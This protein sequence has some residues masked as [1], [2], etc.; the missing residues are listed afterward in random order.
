M[1]IGPGDDILRQIGSLLRH[2]TVTGLSDQQLLERFANDR[3]EVA[4]AALVERH[5]AMVQRACR[6]ILRDEHEAQDAFQ[7][8][9]LLLARRAGRLWI[10]GSLAP[11]L[12]A[13]AWR[14][15]IDA[16]KAAARRRKHERRASVMAPVGVAG[17]TG[18]DVELAAILH[19]EIGR[20]PF[21][22][23]AAVVVCDIEGRTHEEG[24]RL[25]GWPIGTV[26]SRQARARA[27]LARPVDSPRIGPLG[28]LDRLGAGRRASDGWRKPCLG[29]DHGASVRRVRRV[30]S[31]NRNRR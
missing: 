25:L 27:R 30:W 19:E 16:R 21:P 17:G 9:F 4:F 15:A 1:G 23:R 8:A 2:G 12:H 3:D 26:K 5:G 29:R 7:A 14:V 22:Y 31:R 6:G 24:A 28:G 13:V 20:L 10:R 18:G 11:W